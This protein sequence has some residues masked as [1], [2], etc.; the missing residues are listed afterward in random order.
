MRSSKK[1]NCAL[2]QRSKA[3]W[4]P[5]RGV[6][7]GTHY[8]FSL[9]KFGIIILF[10]TH[11]WISRKW[12]SFLEM[13]GCPTVPVQWVI[14]TSNIWLW[15]HTEKLGLCSFRKQDPASSKGSQE[16]LAWVCTW[17]SS[18]RS[19]GRGW[20]ILSSLQAAA[21]LW[22][23][24]SGFPYCCP[25]YHLQL[26]PDRMP[27]GHRLVIKNVLF[28]TMNVSLSAETKE[29]QTQENGRTLPSSAAIAGRMSTCYETMSIV[30]R[31]TLTLGGDW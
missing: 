29:P 5:W 20:W 4:E 1:G 14:Y 21:M 17:I 26:S 15:K 19:K 13:W 12:E 28:I 9:K 8:S 24:S 10:R 11:S 31:G 2:N 18:P 16:N 25:S 27:A 30:S 23:Y 22:G 6:L 7:Q 3:G